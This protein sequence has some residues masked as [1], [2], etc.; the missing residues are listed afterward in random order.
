MRQDIQLSH[1][2]ANVGYPTA[3]EFFERIAKKTQNKKFT[4]FMDLLRDTPVELREQLLSEDLEHFKVQLFDEADV[5]LNYVVVCEVDSVLEHHFLNT[6]DRMYDGDVELMEKGVHIV[7]TP[8]GGSLFGDMRD[9]RSVLDAVIQNI[10][11]HGAFNVRGDSRNALVRWR[12]FDT[13]PHDSDLYATTTKYLDVEGSRYWVVLKPT[14]HYCY[15]GP[16]PLNTGVSRGNKRSLE[17]VDVKP[18]ILYVPDSSGFDFAAILV[19]RLNARLYTFNCG[20]S[21]QQGSVEYQLVRTKVSVSLTVGRSEENEDFCTTLRLL[22][23]ARTPEVVRTDHKTLY[24]L[25]HVTDHHI[26]DELLDSIIQQL[27]A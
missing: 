27:I 23:L 3:L 5:T 8:L 21:E 9:L 20:L 13:P 17:L 18:L 1:F 16:T 14:P 4:T 10:S 2:V 25:A 19:E 7:Y 11:E 24:Y 15:V 22:P 26:P 12:L 6:P